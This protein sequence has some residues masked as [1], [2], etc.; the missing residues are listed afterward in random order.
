MKFLSE[1]DRT[2]VVKFAGNPQ[3][4]RVLPNEFIGHRLAE[5]LGLPCPP[6]GVVHVP[7]EALGTAGCLIVP[8]EGDEFVMES[9]AHFFSTFLAPA[10][11]LHSG[12]LGGSLFQ[13]ID[14][15]AGMA[16]LDLLI[17]NFDRKPA[18]PNLLHY[19]AGWAEIRLIDLSMAFGSANW[20]LGNLLD[21]TLPSPQHPLP[22]AGD[23]SEFFR[24]VQE[25][26]F[27]PYLARLSSLTEHVVGHMMS[28]LPAG[29]GVTADELQALATFVVARA[30]ALP[31]YLRRRLETRDPWWM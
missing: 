10:D 4:P 21:T 30:T 20:A 23:L 24:H 11:V 27:A 12:R 16:V 26:H 1:D 29:W 31:A 13:N 5:H 3:G 19:K 15:L 7:A 17:N 25:E 2:I 9:G 14:A 6:S 28:G 22:Y 18:N 8:F